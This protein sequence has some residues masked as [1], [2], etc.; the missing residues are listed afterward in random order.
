MA[1]FQYL[2]TNTAG[3]QVSGTIT[4][5][6]QNEVAG[7][8]RKKQ[9]TLVNARAVQAEKKAAAGSGSKLTTTFWV[10]IILFGPMGYMIWVMTRPKIKLMEKVL[11]TRQLATMISAG[12]P[13]LECLEVLAE[14]SE[15]A[16]FQRILNEVVEDVRT[17]N[18]LSDSLDKHPAAF[19]KIYVAMT[20]AGEASGQLDVILTRLAEYLEAMAKLRRE[21]V[22]AMTYPVISL[23]MVLGITAFLMI[24][25]V[26]KFKEIFDSLS[27]ELPWIT[28][29]LL[30]LS[31]F[32]KGWWFLFIA[33]AI[34]A[35]IG[36]S[37]FKKTDTGER[38][39]H[40]ILLRV[41]LFGSLFRKVALSRFSRTFATLIQSG[42]PILGALEIV[43]V[44]SG[45]RVVEEAVLQGCEAV[46]TGEA[47]ADPLSRFWVF[48]PM[49]VRMISIG[50]K[51]GALEQ[52]LEKI[53]EFYDQ[54]VSAAVEALTSLIEPLMIGFMGFIVGGIVMAVF[55]P[56]LKIQESLQ[57]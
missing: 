5:N 23:C 33:A 31:L 57:K 30:N 34:G 20:R 56:I 6:S 2:A 52:L 39:W 45:N 38:L 9:L 21:I 27:I 54:Q 49:V 55:L 43:A 24:G 29:T 35:Y 22:G 11:F 10:L 16:F 51:S 50:E 18:D 42:V 3:K 36:F 28:K 17:G 26:P 14:Q 25:I 40:M 44:T 7:E 19:T 48:P 47:L 41:P 37:V 8:L 4:A 12:I 15:N 32:L 1:Q 13:L 53:A 46:K